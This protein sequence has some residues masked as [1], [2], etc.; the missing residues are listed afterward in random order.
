MS[1]LDRLKKSEKAPPCTLTKGSKG[2]FVG[3]VSMQ[4]G[5]SG[6]IQPD[7]SLLDFIDLVRATAACEHQRLLHRQQIAAE[8]DADDLAELRT[9]T[10]EDRQEW[11]ELLAWRLTRRT[12]R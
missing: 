4:D 9:N 8:L 2:A 7:K 6:E 10:R 1:Y 11:A 5:A 3:S 12:A